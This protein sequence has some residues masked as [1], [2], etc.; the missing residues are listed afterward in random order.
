MKIS[1]RWNSWIGKF[2]LLFTGDNGANMHNI[3]AAM[4]HELIYIKFK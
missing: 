4:H 2:I 3:G 1:K